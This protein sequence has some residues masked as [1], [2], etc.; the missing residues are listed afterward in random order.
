MRIFVFFGYFKFLLFN[1]DKSW[2]ST[3]QETEFFG[4]TTDDEHTDELIRKATTEV[5]STVG[6]DKTNQQDKSVTPLTPNSGDDKKTTA[7]GRNSQFPLTLVVCVLETSKL[8][9]TFSNVYT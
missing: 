4:S 7:T 5:I 9:S 3:T 8:R 2:Q 1:L 6:P